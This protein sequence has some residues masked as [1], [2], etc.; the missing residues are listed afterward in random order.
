MTIR[1]STGEK[2]NGNNE[3]FFQLPQLRLQFVKV[4]VCFPFC[5]SQW[6]FDHEE[7]VQFMCDIK[8]GLLDLYQ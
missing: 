1:V 4:G 5:V 8:V 6:F 3:L 2:A 7:L